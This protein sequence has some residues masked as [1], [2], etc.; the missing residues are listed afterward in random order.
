M[1]L[2]KILLSNYLPYAKATIISRA[3]P[4]IDGLK[5]VQRR[6]LYTMNSMGLQNGDK[7]K[8]QK[9]N[10]ATMSIHPHGDSSIYEAAVLLTTGYEGLNVPY[11]ESKGSF[12]KVYSKDLK[13]AA[14]RYTEM[15]LAPICKEMFEGIN[16]NAVDFVDNFDATMKEPTLLP[17]KFPNILV[18]T[19]SGV[20]VGTSSDIPSFSLVNVC[21]ATQGIL[22]DTIKT[23]AELADVLGAPEFTT[24][25]FLH[26]SKDSIEKLCRTGRGSYVISGKVEVYNDRIVIT[27]IPYCTTA[28]DIMDAID[29][30]IKEKKLR[31]I[32]D[33][34]DEI[35][36]EGLRLV[37]EIKNGYNSRDIL[38]ELCRL[39]PLR[40][41]ISFRT[42][43][44]VNNRCKELGLL[45]LLQTWCQF[46]EA[47][48]QRIY[49]F[50][51]EKDTAEEHMLSTWEKIK[52]DI[53]G[54]VQMI[55]RNTDAVAKQKLMENYG[56]EDD[57]AEYLL[58]MKIR[59]ITTD[60]ANKALER[61]DNI[62]VN[63][64]YSNKVINDDTEK[65]NIII[66]ELEDIM[67]KYGK[68]N[69]TTMVDEL[70]EED[71]VTVIMTQDGFVRRVDALKQT[72][73]F[74]AKN[75]DTEVRRWSIKNNDHLLVFDRFGTVHKVLV[76]SIDSSNKAVMTDRLFAMAGIEKAEDVIWI[77]ACGDYSGYFNLIYPNGRGTRV[78]YNK[79]TGTRAQYRSLYSE[80]KPG[81]YWVTQENEFFMITN[82]LKAS[83]C[84]ISRLGMLS[85]RSAFK[86]A[87]VASGDFFTRLQ[88]AKDVP[89]IGLINLDK[90]NK[91]YTVSIGEDILWVDDEQIA[92]SRKLMAQ[93]AEK[94]KQAEK[95]ETDET[96]S[97]A[98]EETD[99]TNE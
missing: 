12:G 94:Y 5:P 20:A 26:A 56:L 83:Y 99:K 37:V 31:G 42:R 15:K 93:I 98:S 28:E 73:K 71:T 88:P 13:Y 55:S 40:T 90:Y 69:K 86:V 53:P 30:A 81:Q 65:K 60:R 1:E 41:S 77:D 44:I 6:L 59:S 48:I 33:V 84:D 14:P 66:K 35:G 92:E 75:G 4:S 70:K 32:K 80:V 82:R 18:N 24:G 29:V 10:G 49:Q 21:K 11:I 50:R 61:L 74:V 95:T 85:N 91:D 17:V 36:L 19:S 72:S 38:K 27:E 79:A 34:N 43:V 62:R 97:D 9:I 68:E 51:L 78:Y 52:H 2:T 64:A 96:K 76:D 47:C 8:S 3:I 45:E 89:N 46:R 7:V 58:D 87:R 16:E 23:P 22:K 39:T 67:Q 25:G 57:Q 54:A 63:I